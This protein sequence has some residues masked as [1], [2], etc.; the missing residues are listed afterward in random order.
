MK[1]TVNAIL[2]AAIAAVAPLASAADEENVFVFRHELLA[3]SDAAREQSD[4]WKRWADD[5]SRDMRTS[6]GT[7]FAGRVGSARTVKGAPYSAEVITE[8]NQ[9][10][11][12]GNV[13][14]RK[15]SGAV[16]R[17]GEGRTRQE[18]GG[19]GRERTIYITDPVEM[20]AYVV[21]P[22]AKRA[23]AT[24][25]SAPRLMSVTD[26]GRHRQV[27]RVGG[28]EVRVEDGKVFVDGKEVKDGR[29]EH[30]APSGKK[31]VVENGRVTI[32]GKDIGAAQPG[33]HVVVRSVDSGDGVRREEVRVQTFRG[34][35]DVPAPPVPPVPPP[36]VR[37]LPGAHP[38]PPI[39]PLPPMPGIQTM[40]FESTA[41][42]G[43][44]VTTALGTKEFDGV[45]AEGKATTWTIPA[46]EIGN[47]NP[48]HV[49]SETW[50]SPEL[51]VTV[52]SRYS[53]PRTGES[54]YRLAGIKRAEPAAELFKVPEDYRVRD[55]TRK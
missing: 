40:R 45:K 48:I 33:S 25:Y 17:D 5:V 26:S 41:K 4:L 7:L 29:V 16:F 46:G 43:K 13:I 23:V 18:S 37:G 31:I 14:S 28:T 20:K 55:R 10:L 24:A 30:V 2:A 8:T 9:A 12:D 21:T 42:L 47:R 1:R 27:V 49:T 32:D 35:D 22:G 53:D 3:S 51:Q 6:M 50:Y 52:M 15:T 11:A 44:G 54:I 36:P 19:D 34:G 39:P 38:L